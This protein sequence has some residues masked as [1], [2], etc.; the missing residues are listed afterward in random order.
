[1]KKLGD[2]IVARYR[3]AEGRSAAATQLRESINTYLSQPT[4]N[5]EKFAHIDGADKQSVIEKCATVQKW[6]DDQ[7]ARQAEKPKN[8]DP[9][10][11]C[12]EI[13]KKKDEIIYFAVP[14]MS[15]PKPKPKVEPAPNGSETPKS[16]TDTPDPSAAGG[17]KTQQQK[18]PKEPSEMDID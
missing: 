9:A 16:R 14:I 5:D 6:L 18:D 2:P 15:K 4:S 17:E 10:V 3:E 11:T 8:V 13:L 1:M 12:A 7:L